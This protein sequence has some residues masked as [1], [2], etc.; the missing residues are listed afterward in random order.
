MA[1]FAATNPSFT[2]YSGELLWG[3]LHCIAEGYFNLQSKT[4]TDTQRTESVSLTGGNIT[5]RNF[6]Y[7][8][9]AV[10]GHWIVREILTRTNLETPPFIVGF[11]VYN[12]KLADPVQIIKRCTKVGISNK[13]DH[14]DRAIVYIN[15]YDWSWTHEI[16]DRVGQFLYAG[17]NDDIKE[18]IKEMTRNRFIL[19]DAMAGP[20]VIHQLKPNAPNV[21]G[22]SRNEL[23][24]QTLILDNY[25]IGVHLACPNTEFELGW[26]IFSESNKEELIAFVYDSAYTALEGALTLNDGRTIRTAKEWEVEL[27][28]QKKTSEELWASFYSELVAKEA[29]DL[30]ANEAED[31]AAKEAVDLAAIFNSRNGKTA[32]QIAEELLLANFVDLKITSNLLDSYRSIDEL[33]QII[34]ALE[35]KKTELQKWG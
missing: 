23:V 14:E 19:A 7:R 17:V 33:Q 32:E 26:M 35:S 25:S 34:D 11:I 31:F 6:M 5:Q 22:I 20:I 24:K 2:C 30:A 15:R 3:Q 9:K 1:T 18:N 16:T 27:D 21:S 28:A 12:S 10:R 4:F 13:Q 29:E 8:V